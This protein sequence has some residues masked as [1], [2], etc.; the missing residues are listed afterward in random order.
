MPTCYQ[1]IGVPGSGK[2]TWIKQQ[3][4]ASQCVIASS[5]DF[6]EQ[7]A[8]RRNKTYSEVFKE[9]I[10]AASDYMMEQIEYARKNDLDIIWDQTSTTVNSRK[11]KFSALPNYDHIAVVFKTPPQR[12]LERRL[13]G[14][15]GKHI[16]DH[17]MRNM[18]RN[19]QYPSLQEGYKEI[20]NIS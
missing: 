12:E 11:R 6:I 2:T 15:P 9:L 3:S 7:E 10:S 19:F 1:L 17:I 14:R 20:W 13:A 8:R 4:W 18:I 5:D 16:P